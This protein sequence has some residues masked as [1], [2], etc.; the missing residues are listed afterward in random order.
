MK[1]NTGFTLIELMIVIAILGILAAIIVPAATGHNA[2]GA[3][4][5]GTPA[6]LSW[7]IN[8]VTESRCIDGYRFVVG[9][10]GGARQIMDE[11][12]RGVRCQ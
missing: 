1:R 10:D 4:G 5:P 11:M 12:G 6:N 3:N 9:H 2:S 8:G 7:G